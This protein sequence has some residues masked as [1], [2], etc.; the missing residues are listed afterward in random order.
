[1]AETWVVP[2]A[3]GSEAEEA[4]RNI[5]A[6]RFHSHHSVLLHM[7]SNYTEAC[8]RRD[9]IGAHMCHSSVDCKKLFKHMQKHRARTALGSRSRMVIVVDPINQPI[10]ADAY[11]RLFKDNRLGII[12]VSTLPCIV[13]DHRM[14]RT[15]TPFIGV[16]EDEEGASPET[17]DAATDAATDAAATEAEAATWSAWLPW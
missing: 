12:V 17:P 15:Y 6:T 10:V 1:M 7:S 14:L 8:A 9:A 11:N 4:I 2:L 13:K 16:E 5:I 3:W